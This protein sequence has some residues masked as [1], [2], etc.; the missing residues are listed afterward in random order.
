ME[1]LRD[2]AE[3]QTPRKFV[4]LSKIV[5]T[6][7]AQGRKTLIWSNFV[8]NLETLGQLLTPFA[9]AIV[10]GG[11]TDNTATSVPGRTRQGELDRFRAGDSGCMV[12]LANPASLGEGV[13]L[14]KACQDAVYLDRTFNAGQ[15]LQSVDRIHRLDEE[16]KEVRITFLETLET[17]DTVVD[18][19]VAAKVVQMGVLLDDPDIRTMNLPDEEDYGG[20]IDDTDDIAAILTHLQNTLP[21]GEG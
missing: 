2:Y 4:E 21:I 6:N 8:R 16:P 5:K 3:Y 19:R 10:H 1:L 12:L 18:Q 17:I 13:S 11:I 14:H 15:Y 9:P 7:A 20:V